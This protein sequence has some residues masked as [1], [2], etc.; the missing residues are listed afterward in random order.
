MS[1]AMCRHEERVT[2]VQC[3]REF[4]GASRKEQ[5]PRR[6]R[7]PFASAQVRRSSQ[8]SMCPPGARRTCCIVRASLLEKRVATEPKKDRTTVHWMGNRKLR[9]KGI[10]MGCEEMLLL[11]TLTYWG[12]I[13]KPMR[14][15]V[16]VAAASSRG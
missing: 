15:E 6:E 4:D 13:W 12:A 5:R 8:K 1:E 11:C 16:R 3:R 10:Y 9:F 14:E 7:L 2:S